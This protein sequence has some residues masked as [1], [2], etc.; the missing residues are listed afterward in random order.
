ME[1]TLYMAQGCNLKCK[2]CYQGKEKKSI[3]MDNKTAKS[4]I[5]FLISNVDESEDIY[6]TFLGGEPLLNFK[7]ISEIIEYISK[8][9]FSYIDRFKYSITTNGTLL[10]D[11]IIS[12]FQ[13]HRFRV[14]VSIDGDFN[15]QK[16]NRDGCTLSMHT[17]IIKNILNMLYNNIACSVRMT[18]TA[19]NVQFFYE[20]IK[21]FYEQGIKRYDIGFD[22][23]S[24]W[25][26]KEIDILSIE[27]KKIVEFYKEYEMDE[28]LFI[29]ILDDKIIP[30]I[31]KR[32]QY[33]CNAG[34]NGHFVVDCKGKIYPCTYVAGNNLWEIG[35]VWEGINQK[36]LWEQI[37]KSV[38]NPSPCL[39]CDIAELCIGG[40]CGFMNYS[41]S[42]FLNQPNEVECKIEKILFENQ[43]SAILY[44]KQTGSRRIEELLKIANEYQT[45]LSDF[46][47]SLV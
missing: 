1:C 42:G 11:E 40:Q 3:I 46:A 26:E 43:K 29:N 47:K 31:T 14:S 21:Y 38:K 6:V 37:R 34:S 30:H 16:I 5:K 35:N 13:R 39:K 24:M 44:L 12:V 17:G 18:V 9:Y 19:N 8:E 45:E 15:T 22:F 32:T 36:K 23:F 25:E 28:E 10:N 20:N 33:Y 27:M 2:Y 7:M 4:V 41:L